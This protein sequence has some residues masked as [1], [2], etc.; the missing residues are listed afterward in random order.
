MT[1]T[2]WNAAQGAANAP[3]ATLHIAEGAGHRASLTLAGFS[4][5]QESALT[6]SFASAAG[7]AYL[8]LAA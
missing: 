1:S 7:R 2:D 3:G 8:H 6:V 4:V 5:G